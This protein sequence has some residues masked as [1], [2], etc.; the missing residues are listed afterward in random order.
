MLFRS[1]NEV[2]ACDVRPGGQWLFAMVAP[3]GQSWANHCEFQ[4]LDAPRRLEIRHVNAPWFT[5]GLTLLAEPGGTRLDW[6]Q[7]FDDAATAEAL[8]ARVTP[9]NE[10]NL[11]RLAAELSRSA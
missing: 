2:S 8:R 6:D 10:E 11:D 5:L 7:C 4:T 1:R 3:D 9:A